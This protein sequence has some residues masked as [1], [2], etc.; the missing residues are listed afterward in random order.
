MKNIILAGVLSVVAF[1]ASAKQT[2]VTQ[3]QLIESAKNFAL[4]MGEKMQMP[5]TNPSMSASRFAYVSLQKTD[6]SVAALLNNGWTCDNITNAISGKMEGFIKHFELNPIQTKS[7]K[8]YQ[9]AT[10]E[11]AGSKCQDMGGE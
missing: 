10:V 11:Y 7:F 9:S 2:F 4:L 6:Q 3:A 5:N 8:K 1:G